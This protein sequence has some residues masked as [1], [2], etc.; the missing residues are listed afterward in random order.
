MLPTS[1]KLTSVATDIL[2]LQ[3]DAYRLLVVTSPGHPQARTLLAATDPARLI[4][5]PPKDPLMLQ[6]LLCG[7][8]L[9]HD[10]LPEAHQLAQNIPTESGSFWHAILHRREGDFANSKHWY[11]QCRH[12]PVLQALN[13]QAAQVLNP[14][15]ADKRLLKLTWDGW[16][17]AYLVDLV[18]Q[19]HPDTKDEFHQILIILQQLEWK[20]LMEYCAALA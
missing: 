5:Q 6:S 3:P 8:W 17:P 7:L 2:Q 20:V 16:N 15:P 19:Y 13:N 18:A 11:S 1:P 12:H 9:W 14:L 10:C 4:N